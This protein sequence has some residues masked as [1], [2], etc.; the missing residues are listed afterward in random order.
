MDNNAFLDS[1]ADLNS[2][3]RFAS[4]H[5]RFFNVYIFKHKRKPSGIYLTNYFY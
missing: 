2:T 3:G 5:R 4:N 1:V